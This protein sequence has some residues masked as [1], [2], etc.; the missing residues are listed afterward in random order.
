MQ[1]FMRRTTQNKGKRT[2]FKQSGPRLLRDEDV[3]YEDESLLVV[4]KPS[5]MLCHPTKGA[6][7]GDKA[8]LVDAAIRHCKPEQGTSAGNGKG[9]GAEKA[10]GGTKRLK[11]VK[12]S[13]SSPLPGPSA[14]PEIGTI[15]NIAREITGS[16]PTCMRRLRG[17]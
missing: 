12:K 8:T 6:G 4:N 15:T 14:C 10:K 1:C 16:S 5:G 11:I 7:S 3:L 2:K 9:K 13:T 17:L